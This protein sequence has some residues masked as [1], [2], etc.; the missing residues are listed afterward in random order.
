MWSRLRLHATDVVLGIIASAFGLVS[1]TYPFARDHALFFYGA[2]EWLL[3][4]QVLYRDI[5][6]HKP[7]GIY[8]IYA[9]AITLFGQ[10]AWGIRLLEL[11]VGV[12]AMAYVTAQLARNR[13]A[14]EVPG[15]LGAAWLGVALID[16]GYMSYWDG[17]QCEFWFTLFSAAALALVI[18]ARRFMLASAVAGVLSALAV[19]VKP[20]SVP[21]VVITIGAVVWR[22]FE[23]RPERWQCLVRSLVLFATAGGAVTACVI[24]YYGAKHALP[25]MAD[26]LIG[27]NNA[28]VRNGPGVR[29]AGD[30]LKRASIF[31]QEF[32]PFSGI[33]LAFAGLA[34]LRGLTERD[35]ALLRRYL[36]PALL[37]LAC[38]TSMVIQRKFYSYHRTAIVAG[39]AV[40]LAIMFQR[41]VQ[42]LSKMPRYVAPAVFVSC[43]AGLFTLSDQPAARWY[44]DV[45]TALSWKEGELSREEF[46]RHYDMPDYPYHD[47][48]LAGLWLRANSKPDDTV[49]VRDLIRRSMT[50][51]VASTRGVSAGAPSS[52]KGG[53]PITGMNGWL[54]TS[55]IALAPARVCRRARWGARGCRFG[56]VLPRPRIRG[57]P[58][59]GSVHHPSTTRV[60]VRAEQRERGQGQHERC[61]GAQDF[62]VLDVMPRSKAVGI[63]VSIPT[64]AVSTKSERVDH[65]VFVCA[66][67]TSGKSHAM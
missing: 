14:S 34:T 4:D 46:T 54:R 51:A 19:L 24:A 56:A 30:V 31:V 64:P 22:A 1:L 38:W 65:R 18:H 12:P 55:R 62:I 59:H 26:L 42:L 5:L 8:A 21:F 33:M 15:T 10:N 9:F 41:A 61:A 2:R 45:T 6:D 27:L 53:A 29:D 60:A 47:A 13:G 36:I 48:E 67:A 44:A 32:E 28:H 11:V 3:R 37:A 16:Y 43:S 52:R 23:A 25:E 17:A 50:S 7:P 39:F 35:S 58:T 49:I 57:S 40:A 20:S 66:S 63:V